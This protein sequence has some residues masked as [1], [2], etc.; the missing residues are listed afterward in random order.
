MRGVITGRDVVA[1]LGVVWREFGP[2][3]VWRCLLACVTGRRAT[4]LSLALG[5][6]PAPPDEERP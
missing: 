4:F 2:R 3:C 1:N 5:L 6:P